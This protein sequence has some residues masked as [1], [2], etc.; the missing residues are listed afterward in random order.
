[1][2]EIEAMDNFVAIDLP[3]YEGRYYTLGKKINNPIHKEAEAGFLTIS[4]FIQ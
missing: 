4:V 1:M 2:H 3:T